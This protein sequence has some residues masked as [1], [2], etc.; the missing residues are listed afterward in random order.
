MTTEFIIKNETHTVG[1]LLRT[2]LLKDSNVL[3]AAYDIKHPLER[4]VYI[5]LLTN[6]NDAKGTIIK[7]N[8]ILQK[9]I[10]ILQKNWNETKKKNKL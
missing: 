9:N 7:A 4:Q 6:N 8:N 10:E 1:N 5:S 3:F 2:Q